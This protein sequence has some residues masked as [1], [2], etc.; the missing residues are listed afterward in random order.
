MKENSVLMLNSIKVLV[1]RV[2]IVT[3]LLQSGFSCNEKKE[4]TAQAEVNIQNEEL[5]IINFEGYKHY[6]NRADNKTY[7][8]KFCATWCATCVKEM[9][10]F[11]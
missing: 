2:L 11:K 5:K 9:P 6:L 8:I 7:I 3:V 1:H 10:Y 4:T